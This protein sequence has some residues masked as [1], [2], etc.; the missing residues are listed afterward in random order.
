MPTQQHVTPLPAVQ[1]WRMQNNKTEENKTS[2]HFGLFL[3]L[4]CSFLRFLLLFLQG[5]LWLSLLLLLCC[6]ETG[7]NAQHKHFLRLPPPIS[8]A[9]HEEVIDRLGKLILNYHHLQPLSMH[10]F[11]SHCCSKQKLLE[12]VWT[13]ARQRKIWTKIAWINSAALRR[14]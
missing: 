13:E 14:C 11:Y 2:D 7:R 9:S 12:T 8:C 5:F 1:G 4:L 6:P 3:S 10:Y